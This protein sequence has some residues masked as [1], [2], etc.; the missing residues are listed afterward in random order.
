MIVR[1]ERRDLKSEYTLF[2]KFS[3]QLGSSKSINSE[4]KRGLTTR[5]TSF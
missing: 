2:K 3:I 1:I 5:L 4:R